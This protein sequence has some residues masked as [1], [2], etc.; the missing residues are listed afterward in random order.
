LGAYFCTVPTS[1]AH[2]V[3]AEV[4]SRQDAAAAAR[5]LTLF[6]H[7]KSAQ[8]VED[9]DRRV[10]L[11]NQAFCDMFG[12]PA[13]PDQLM[14]T[15]CAAAAEAVMPLFRDPV[16]FKRVT[17]HAVATRESIDREILELVDGRV[18]ERDYTAV[19][20]GDTFYGHVWTY[21]DI[22]AARRIEEEN[23]R[24]RG[25]YEQVLD[26]MPAQVAVFDEQGRF[27]YVNRASIGDAEVRAWVLGRTNEDYC[28]HRN[29]P[30][31]IGEE[32]SRSIL[33]VFASGAPEYFE[34]T[35]HRH[36]KR[37]VIER[38]LA[39][40]K[41]A[42]G[43][44][45]L[46]IGFGRDLTTERQ[47]QDA[48]A[49]SEERLRL[50][51]QGGDLATWDW[52]LQTGKIA[53]NAR[54]DEM[55]GY[56]PGEVTPT[57]DAWKSTVHPDDAPRVMASL[58]ANLRGETP[59]HESEHRMRH[60]DGHYIWVFGR[61][62][63]LA[64]SADGTPLRMCGTS[65]DITKR[66]EAE[67]EVHLARAAAE[68][69]TAARERFLAN[70]S[71]ELRTPLN[72]IVGLSHHLA[73][74]GTAVDQQRAIEGI[75]FSADNLLGVINDLLDMTRIRSGHME[76]DA[77]PFEIRTLLDGL[78]NSLQGTA[79]AQGLSLKLDV[80]AT[81][82]TMLVGDPVRL[83]QVLS[84]LV[85]NALKF[86]T[87]GGV[88]VQAAPAALP[89]GEPGIEIVVSDTGI[90]IAPEDRERVFDP[91]LQA[92]GELTRSSGGTG[93]GLS[94]VRDLVQ[95]MGG[96][97]A[98]ESRVG[99]G[100]TFRVVLPLIEATA[101][102]EPSSAPISMSLLAGL[103]VLIVE[104]N[105]MNSYVARVVLE[106]AG[107][108]VTVVVNGQEALD[109][110]RHV[111]HD[112]V[113]MDI[114]MPVMDGFEASWRIRNELGLSE[115]ELPI[116]ALTATA[117]AD[118]QRRA[119]ASGM[120]DYIMKPFKP[121]SLCLRIAQ[122]LER[123]G[124]STS[125]MRIGVSAPATP[126]VGLLAG[127]RVLLVE[128]NEMNR[129]VATIFLEQSGAEVVPAASGADALALL[130]RERFDIALM[131][132][133]MPNM[134]GFETTRRI[135]EDLGLSAA[136]LPVVALTATTLSDTERR[137][138]AAEMSDYILK[139]FHPDLLCQRVAAILATTTRATAAT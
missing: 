28:R 104:D 13:T 136:R 68:E 14:G 27:Q 10:A 129:R 52:D 2:S 111:R 55:L 114:Q 47:A 18:L 88:S 72:A 60:T 39:P 67:R 3:A 29:V 59:F 30:V 62:R 100:S 85:G 56:G 5:F 58:E 80:D 26:S 16:S 32:R 119:N 123:A 65:I 44:V 99:V 86:T 138:K 38:S 42:D 90:G 109:R 11:V 97:I 98:L 35:M 76:L 95:Q 25:F 61:G 43:K 66:R 105:E 64:R 130:G 117:L 128:D 124:R 71:H 75:R 36:G 103:E 21:R 70:I 127:R 57:L 46:V 115:A 107:A 31:E 139:P 63:V 113:L 69:A 101:A 125:E 73:R 89:S 84:N 9:Q 93:L 22:T 102:M 137:A 45:V 17:D 20:S 50:A 34:E 126:D 15:D 8:L 7:L 81:L 1:N 106:H 110:L 135:R 12:I 41:D 40:I 23:A 78:V 134:D 51:L 96:T 118:E 79:Q 92:S 48:L 4:P 82:P 112:V 121:E 131:D 49:D 6:Q 83:N 132:I 19:F 91:F 74:P 77:L 37:H 53:I 24:L 116:I 122:I 108:H 33:S 120:T 94:I 87:V 133:Q 54:F